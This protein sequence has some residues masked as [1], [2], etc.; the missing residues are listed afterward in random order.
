MI[1]VNQAGIWRD[2]RMSKSEELIDQDLGTF[3]TFE[4]CLKK[5]FEISYFQYYDGVSAGNAQAI[6][7][8][9]NTTE[10]FAMITENKNGKIHG[11]LMKNQNLS[12][13]MDELMRNQ[14]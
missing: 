5:L 11:R 2:H 3:K 14:E 9:N 13:I 4:D 8:K 12:V 6:I 7:Y 10:Q 1:I